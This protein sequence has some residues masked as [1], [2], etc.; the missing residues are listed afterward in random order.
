MGKITRNSLLPIFLLAACGCQQNNQSSWKFGDGAQQFWNYI[1]GNT[2]K[3]AV[4]EME[5]AASPDARREGI[6]QLVSWKFARKPPY[7]TRYEQIARA[8]SDWLV[9]ATAIRALNRA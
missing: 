3:K 8:D 6:N 7:T 1:T 5:D 9:R 2:P 4:K